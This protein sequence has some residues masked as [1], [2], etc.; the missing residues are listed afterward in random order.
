[1]A[2]VSVSA[3]EL[4][5]VESRRPIGYDEHAALGDGAVIVYTVEAGIGSGD[6]PIKLAGDAGRGHTYESPIL[7]VGE[8]VT[9]R[10]YT[11][12]V[13]ADDGDTHTVTISKTDDG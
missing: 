13:I 4:I 10:G 3:D 12:T 1:M 5:V 9:V 8:S 2:A 6:L 7:T 11:I